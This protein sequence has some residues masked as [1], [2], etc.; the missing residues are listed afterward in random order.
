ME[1]EKIMTI[2]KL[3]ELI[4]SNKS[5]ELK[6]M[7]ADLDEYLIADMI[8]ILEPEK[9]VV[10]FR[11]LDKQ[12]ALDVF[13]F[14]ETEIQQDL[15]QNFTDEK[16]I[17]FF[18]NLEPDDRAALMDELPAKV[19]KRLLQALSKKERDLTTLVM[20]YQPGTA[21]HIMTPKYISFKQGMTVQEAL[22]RI[23]EVADEV[24]TVYHLY[25]TDQTRK[26]EG[27]V[28]LKDLIV[29]DPQEKIENIMRT[30]PTHVVHDAPDEVVAQLL[31]DSDMLAVPI[32][33]TEQRLLGV[34]TV[35]DAIDILEDEAV[36]REITAAG[37][38]DFSIR[39]RDRSRIL[40]SGKLTQVLGVRVPFLLITLAGG[41]FAGFVIGGFE[42]ILES[43]VVL[44]FFIPVIMDMGGNVGTQSSTIFSRAVALGQINFGRFIKQWG[45]EVGIGALMGLILGLLGGVIV[46]IWQG[47]ILDFELA[48]QLAIVI[49]TALF[50]TI[51]I[52]TALGFFVP[53]V[54]LKIGA[55]SAASSA[56]F[57]TT[58]KD[59]TGLLIYF[60][61]ATWLLGAIM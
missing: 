17:E 30:D 38:I 22:N 39:E 56:P 27:M 32:V 51:V 5:D 41:M 50:M 13:E 2:K 4:D 58:I 57:I 40:T 10:V 45:R 20:G 9:Q 59:I 19:A 18:K 26:L 1:K 61:L 48:I 46:Y 11:L 29:N 35:D 8:E 16:A 31:Q 24:E 12:T 54:M 43:I 52:A 23:R 37:F 25:V 7:L 60:L 14:I 42:A 33:D 28:L 3:R 47:M 6:K 55:D 44:A 21:G 53:Y 15:I 49:S 36:D 34:V